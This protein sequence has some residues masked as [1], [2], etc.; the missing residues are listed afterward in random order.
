MYAGEC[1]KVGLNIAKNGIMHFNCKN[2]ME[3]I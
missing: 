2:F 1:S 3:K